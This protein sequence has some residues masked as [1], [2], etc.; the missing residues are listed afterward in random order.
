VIPD[1]ERSVPSEGER[2]RVAVVAG[3]DAG[4]A[5]PAIALARRLAAAGDEAVVFTGESWQRWWRPRRASDDRV[6][7]ATLPGL[8]HTGGPDTDAGARLSVRAA[9][10]TSDLIAPLDAQGVD[11]VVG[12]VITVCGGWA[13]ETL[14]LPWVELSP[15]PLYEP[16]RGLPP[17]GSGLAPGRGLRGRA[18]DAVMRTLSARSRAQGERQRGAARAS[19]GLP[20]AAPGP[21]ARLI[22]T[23]PVLE[24]PRPDWP[25]RAHLVGPLLW[26]PT[27]EVFTPPAGD[28][29]VV[30]VAPS[31]AATGVAGLAE[32]VLA[33]L[34]PEVTGVPVRVVVSALESTVDTLPPWA[35]AG[36]GRQDRVL[37]G[38]SLTVCGGG[39]GML[40]KSLAA[41]VPVVAVPGGGDQW[42]LANRV[43]R[44]GVGAC[45][46]PPDVAAVRAACLAVL[47]D[48]AVG[49]A[50]RRAALGVDAVDDP[51]AVCHA[52]VE[53]GA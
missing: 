15:H 43:L 8:D 40:A 53:A 10:M 28:G 3:P 52:V 45:V 11:L 47:A 35:V 39:H 50:A 27:D 38:A 31:T 51:V 44:A 5:I 21:S 33:A 7:L 46:R 13:A 25:E 42:E 18:R 29:P 32:T 14:R 6:S 2:V 9:Q 26:E 41:G 24:L 17:I 12:D 37:G 30:V 22:A 49:A 48:P 34:D 36:T 23:L 20:V 4:H 16:S 19:I 1:P